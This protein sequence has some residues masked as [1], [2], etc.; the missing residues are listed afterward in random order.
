MTLELKGYYDGDNR[1]PWIHTFREK[2]FH[3]ADPRPEEID[4]LD[5]ANA[6]SK[7]CR[8]AGHTNEFY[9]VA[10]HSVYVSYMTL[11]PLQGLLHDASEAY[12]VD[13]PSPIKKAMSQYGAVEDTIMNAIA[14]KFGFDWPKSEDTEDADRAM[15][16]E[17]AKALL[18]N[19]DWVNDPKYHPLKRK[20]GI[21]PMCL[22][23]NAA[24][25]L[26]Y[27]RFMQVRNRAVA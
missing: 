5:I 4:I 6:L 27:K 13:M 16:I 3:F 18:N 17:E 12:L 25:E 26:F 23:P 21:P 7:Q 14:K 2:K 15:L 1:G 11:D 24:R 8:F 22:A 19:P 9:S 20:F 10:E